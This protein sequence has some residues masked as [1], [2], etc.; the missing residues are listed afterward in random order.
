MVAGLIGGLIVAQV[1]EGY[2]TRGVA[3]PDELEPIPFTLGNPMAVNTFLDLEPDP[4]V[5]QRSF[6]MIDAAGFG[7]IRQSI[8][9]FD[10]EPDEKGVFLD[11][12]GNSSWAKFDQMVALAEQHDIEIIARLEKPPRWARAGQPNLEQFPDGPPNS[13]QDWIDYVSAVATRY[14]G[15]IHYYQIWNEPNLEGEWGSQP[16]DPRGYVDLLQA[17]YTTIKTIDPGA[18]VLLAGLAPTEQRG[19]DNLSELLFLQRV[20]DYGGAAYFDIA[21]AMVYGYGYSPYDRRVSFERNNFSRVIQMREI[22]VRN[23]DAATPIWA[24]EYGWVSLPDDWQGNPSPWGNPVSP[25]KQAEYLVS[26]YL[27]A[28]REWPWMGV[29]SVWA[30]RFA[31]PPDDPNQIG[32][33]TRGFALVDHDFTPRPAYLALQA[34]APQIQRIGTGAYAATEAMNANLASS[35]G[36]KLAITGEKL[37]LTVEPGA[38]GTLTITRGN[39]QPHEVELEPGEPRQITA[40]HNLSDT[41]HDFT[42]KLTADIQADPPQLLQFTV[43]RR[44]IYLWIGP[45]LD[46]AIILLLMLNLGSLGWALFDWRRGRESGTSG[47]SGTGARE[48]G[49]GWESG[50]GSR[51]SG[52]GER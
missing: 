30:F 20:Y 24:V 45:W 17:A 22:M 33:P 11:R 38:G 50:V 27:R 29:M 8:G 5:V 4:A 37:Q 51:E 52:V 42:L 47:G 46:A 23:N 9:W 31:Q 21:A 43:S 2:F 18:V 44:P 48:P 34:A 36:L 49:L 16:I 19:P 14:K 1:V 25:E 15:K 41:N 35:D 28:Q 26:G 3:R 13:I 12:Y 40:A 39:G 10:L 6:E 32:N 7:Y